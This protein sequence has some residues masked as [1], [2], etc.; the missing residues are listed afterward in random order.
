M[1]VAAERCEH[2]RADERLGHKTE[3]ALGAAFAVAAHAGD[4][5]PVILDAAKHAFV[6]G[7]VQS[8][9]LGVGMAAVAFV[10]LVVRG[11]GRT[12][13]QVPSVELEAVAGPVPVG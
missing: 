1:V 8:M 10:Y 6:E 3:T 12:A 13:A 7:W 11:P 5:G 4:Q 9:W 2:Q